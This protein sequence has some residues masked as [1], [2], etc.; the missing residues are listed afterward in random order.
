MQTNFAYFSS[1]FQTKEAAWKQA[2]AIFLEQ[3]MLWNSL[4]QFRKTLMN[5]GKNES[6][7]VLS[8]AQFI[9]NFSSFLVT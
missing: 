1:Y 5:I 4:G 7:I 9:G 3:E 2:D 8:L 6:L